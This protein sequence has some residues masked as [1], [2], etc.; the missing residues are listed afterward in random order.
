MEVSSTRQ[1]RA[2][3]AGAGLGAELGASLIG[4]ALVGL[5]IDHS[6]DTGPWGT[7]IAV[8]LGFVGGFYNFI[9]SSLRVLRSPLRQG[10]SPARDE[11]DSTIR[12]G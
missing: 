6:F 3:L 10:P 5:W 11:K 4:S 1:P 2:R 7:I 12:D 8:T 9:R